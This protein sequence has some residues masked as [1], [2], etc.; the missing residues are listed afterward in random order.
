MNTFDKI[1]SK[2]WGIGFILILFSWAQ[3]IPSWIG[4]TA[5]I[6]VSIVTILF[7]VIQYFIET[8]DSDFEP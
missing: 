4:W 1:V 2:L 6:T 7:N 5:F 3:L 8:P